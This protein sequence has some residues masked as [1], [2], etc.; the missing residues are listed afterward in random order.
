M[1]Q[2]GVVLRKRVLP[3]QRTPS[4]SNKQSLILGHDLE[5]ERDPHMG[6]PKSDMDLIWMVSPWLLASKSQ[7]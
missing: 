7:V 6:R 2:A 5:F 4:V 1:E 3:A